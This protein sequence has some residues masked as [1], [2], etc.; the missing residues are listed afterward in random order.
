MVLRLR[1]W[2]DRKANQIPGD[3]YCVGVKVVCQS[4]AVTWVK[5]NTEGHVC[6]WSF[7]SALSSALFDFLAH[8]LKEKFCLL[9][10]TDIYFDN[11]FL[12][13]H[14]HPLPQ[15]PRLKISRP[16]GWQS[17]RPRQRSRCTSAGTGKREKG[18]TV[19]GTAVVSET[20]D[21]TTFW[22]STRNPLKYNYFY[23]C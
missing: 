17:S 18:S 5:E 11:F 21:L 13:V 8:P 20:Q 22:N 6:L 7:L 16:R 10:L 14:P 3:I 12:R 15:C 23:L 4:H 1:A 19:S 2:P 9:P